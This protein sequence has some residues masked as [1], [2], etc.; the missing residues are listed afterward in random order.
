MIVY[1]LEQ[2]LTGEGP[3][4]S[5]SY[6][7]CHVEQHDPPCSYD[8]I[9][10]DFER[11]NDLLMTGAFFG[12]TTIEKMNWF[13]RRGWRALHQLDYV[14]TEIEVDEKN[15]FVFHDGQVIFVKFSRKQSWSVR[16]FCKMHDE[17]KF[18][19]DV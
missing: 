9:G 18:G 5:S 15:T 10:K 6:G 16:E 11:M 13:I 1:R 19:S 8:L 12:W 4:T 2:R 7:G 3:F 14:V 17:I